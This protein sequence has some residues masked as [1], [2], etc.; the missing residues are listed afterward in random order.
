MKPLRVDIPF[1]LLRLSSPLAAVL[2][3][4]LCGFV[5]GREYIESFLDKD[6]LHLLIELMST[7]I[8]L[9]LASFFLV[10]Q[11]AE[12][13][14]HRFWLALS[15]LVQGTLIGFHALIPAYPFTCLMLTLAM[16]Y[17]AILCAMVWLPI[18]RVKAD[19]LRWLP[20]GVVC[21]SAATGLGLQVWSNH[22]AMT[23]SGFDVIRPL[24]HLNSV[25]GVLFF[26]ASV[27]LMLLFRRHR[28]W[29]MLWMSV[30]TTVLGLSV[31]SSSA[32]NMAEGW[33]VWHSLRLAGLIMLAL[34]TVICTC[35][36]FRRLGLATRKL[37][38]NATRFKAITE[39]TSDIVFILGA[40]GVFTYVSPAAARIAGVG[41]EDLLGHKPGGFTHAEDRQRVFDG[42]KR[43]QS[44][45][46][47]SVRIG[48]IR[49]RHADGHWLHLEGIYTA[50]YDVSGVEGVVLN[51][52]NITDRI[53]SERALRQSRRQFTTLIGNLPGMVYRSRGDQDFT[54]EYV[55][56]GVIDLMGYTPAEFME[57]KTVTAVDVIHPE[58]FPYVRTS[59]WE[60][61]HEHRPFQLQYRIITREGTQKWVWEQGV[62]I[63]DDSD[64]VKSVEGFILDVTERVLAEDKL[65]RTEYSINSASDAVYWIDRDGSIDEV[66]ET[67]CRILGYSREE[68]L[69]M[70]IFDVSCELDPDEWDH[71][72]EDVKQR[73][74]VL[75]EG[76]HVTKSGRRFPVEIS[77]NYQ[78][79]GGKRFHCSF[80]RDISERKAAEDQIQR[81]NQELEMRV[82]ERTTELQQAQA[83]LVISEKMAALGNLVAGVAH[84]INTPLGIGVTA[85]SHLQQQLE[86]FSGR[87]AA[88][89]LSRSEFETFL[90]A[91]AETTDMI[92][93]NLNRAAEL[94]QSFKQVSVDQS[95]EHLR[96]FEVGAYLRETLISLKPKLKQGKHA[97]DLSCSRD[98]TMTSYPGVLAQVM[99]NLVMNSMIHGFENREGGRISVSIDAL[100]DCIR[101]LYRDDGHGMTPE[102][103]HKIYDPFYTTKRGQGGS[104]LGMNIV[105]NQITQ[106]LK[107]TIEC[108][109]APEQ[110]TAF[111]IELPQRVEAE[112]P[113]ESVPDGVLANV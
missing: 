12:S 15:L 10:R 28:I 52:R 69:G 90:S 72:W 91:G 45:P 9:G 50:M 79:F 57:S 86:R 109:S 2:L 73:G 27:K 110:G 16:F 36:E 64:Q 65:R 58:D 14:S 96:R 54:I 81:M 37:S 76:E 25:S 78:E 40:K 47:E 77:S 82:E 108:Q 105:F 68:L 20:F 87:Y 11:R 89:T 34:Y 80:V 49:V 8:S 5:V 104:G 48:V 17:G 19:M 30:F 51:Y 107:G 67:A 21:A 43:S 55:N 60:A 6:V 4:L 75:I 13:S 61:V 113:P 70:S 31:L 56:D 39:N 84:E 63:Y 106:M 26:A 94:V 95:T 83:Q 97:L 53:L 3:P 24:L 32:Q 1:D 35:Q 38:Q 42:L 98:V 41:E 92:L 111:V 23:L 93:S 62:G 18:R 112:A 66:N 100:G 99:T 71:V 102:Q 103:V 85:A 59:I 74:S 33:L 101:I 7:G 22:S 46:G 29:S 88:K 44:R